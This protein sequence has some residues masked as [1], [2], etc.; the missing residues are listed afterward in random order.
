MYTCTVFASLVAA[1]GRVREKTNGDASQ[2][3]QN[4]ASVLEH[5]RRPLT[6][7]QVTPIYSAFLGAIRHGIS[8]RGSLTPR[9]NEQ[10]QSNRTGQKDKIERRARR[11]GWR[12]L[13]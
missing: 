4:A 9:Q 11:M 1:T 12:C 5:F 8:R 2:I 13:P 10:K 3:D 7:N 6:S